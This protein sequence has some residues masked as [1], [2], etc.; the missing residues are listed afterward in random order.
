MGVA[1]SRGFLGRGVGQGGCSGCSRIGSSWNEGC[2][3]FGGI[4]GLSAPLLD[5]SAEPGGAEAVRNNAALSTAGC[6]WIVVE[7]LCTVCGEEGVLLVRSA[8]L[9]LT[10]TSSLFFLALY[11]SRNPQALFTTLPLEESSLVLEESD[12]ISSLLLER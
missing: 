3:F 10:A 8:V 12:T 9:R 2:F 11:S 1:R 6:T 7:A 5:R 4:L